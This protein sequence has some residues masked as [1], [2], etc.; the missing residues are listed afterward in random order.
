MSC[1]VTSFA[2]NFSAGM[3]HPNTKLNSDLMYER[4]WTR[5]GSYGVGALFGWM[6]YE[7]TQRDKPEFADS[8]F[9]KLFRAMEKSFFL[10][11]GIIIVGLGLMTA[12][13][14]GIDG[15]IRGTYQWPRFPSA[16]YNT[17]SRSIWVLGLG[18]VIIPTYVN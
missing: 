8:I 6:Y 1:F 16:L 3:N 13:V 11:Y 15:P 4:P 2:G 5:F 18:M 10:S 12:M 17:F 14:F 9:N 7:F